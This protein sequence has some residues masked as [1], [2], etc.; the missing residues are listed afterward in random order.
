M[1]GRLV[2]PRWSEREI[3]DL[4]PDDLKVIG[5]VVAQEEDMHGKPIHD[6]WIIRWIGSSASEFEPNWWNAMDL[7]IIH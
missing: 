2:K 7:E 5:L 6:C 4:H 1:I 3:L